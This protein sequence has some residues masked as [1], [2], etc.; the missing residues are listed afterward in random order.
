MYGVFL[1]LLGDTPSAHL[2]PP[3]NPQWLERFTFYL[4]APP[5]NNISKTRPC[6]QSLKVFLA[7]RKPWNYNHCRGITLGL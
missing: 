7:G 3:V 6:T 5:S 1:V 4:K 2:P